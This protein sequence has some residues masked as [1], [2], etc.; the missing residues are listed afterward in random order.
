MAK[1]STNKYRRADSETGFLATALDILLFFGML[2]IYVLGRSFPWNVLFF[3]ATMAV[4]YLRCFKVRPRL[5]R[6][7]SIGSLVLTGAF[8]VFSFVT[9]NR[10]CV[11]LMTVLAWC[12]MIWFTLLL[13]KDK[14]TVRNKK[15]GT[16][17]MVTIL[18]VVWSVLSSARMG[19]IVVTT[20]LRL[21]LC[22]VPIVI[23]CLTAAV[24]YLIRNP[25][26]KGKI[27]IC[28]CVLL[29][30]TVMGFL[31]ISNLNYAFDRSEPEYF[32]C[33]ITDMHISYSGRRNRR[34]NYTFRLKLESG[35]EFQMPVSSSEYKEYD[36]GDSYKIAV[37]D[38]AFGAE[39]CLGAEE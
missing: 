23:V 34:V 8:G 15:P 26:T 2:G 38:G 31:S 5:N 13:A 9:D 12:A 3:G 37:Y 29:F 24:I 10:V 14:L 11:A 1:Y 4:L 33:E 16:V 22:A 32:I 7:E 19:A 6:E 17:Q 30:S 28:L 20:Y 27:G 39:Y 21:L 36:I 18:I 25:K 35:Q